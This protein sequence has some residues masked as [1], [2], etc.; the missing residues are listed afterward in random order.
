MELF[1]LEYAKEES[2]VGPVNNVDLDEK[3][4]NRLEDLMEPDEACLVERQGPANFERVTTQI[5]F[6][7]KK[8]IRSISIGLESNTCPPKDFLQK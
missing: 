1:N 4:Q 3:V 6:E 8:Q 5:S 7:E 2:I